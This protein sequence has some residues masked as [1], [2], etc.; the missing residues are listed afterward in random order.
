MDQIL[1]E[2]G[3]KW[4]TLSKD[5]QV[6]LA[7]TVAGTRQYSNFMALM[8]NYQDAFKTNLNTAYNAQGE[9]NKQADEYAESWE[10]A[11]NR[12]K[13]SAEGI[14]NSLFNIIAQFIIPPKIRIIN[15]MLSFDNL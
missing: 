11:R 4:N 2:L 15:F 14:Y 10:A 7:N 1:D 3:A 5:E 6:A 13:A 9:L 8:N 12:V